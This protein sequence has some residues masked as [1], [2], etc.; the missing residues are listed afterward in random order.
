MFLY[1]DIMT[2]AYLELSKKQPKQQKLNYHK[3]L[4]ENALLD[5]GMSLSHYAS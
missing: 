1:S 4:N 5:K 2:P 3:T